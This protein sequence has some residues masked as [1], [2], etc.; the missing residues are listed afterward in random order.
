ML[1]PYFRYYK[2]SQLLSYKRV[3]QL[4]D[5]VS[6]LRMLTTQ[7]HDQSI[8]LKKVDREVEKRFSLNEDCDVCCNRIFASESYSSKCYT[9]ISPEFLGGQLAD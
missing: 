4:N 8:T 7:A 5:H 1:T 9:I 6:A 2:L 3:D